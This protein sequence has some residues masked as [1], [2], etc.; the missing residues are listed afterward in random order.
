MQKSGL[1]LVNEYRHQL[2]EMLA[3]EIK[4]P[5]TVVPLASVADEYFRINDSY[6]YPA[7]RL[8]IIDQ[9]FVT[10]GEQLAYLITGMDKSP[11]VLP[12][13]TQTRI[14]QETAEETERY[15]RGLLSYT[16]KPLINI[17][18]FDNA[19]NLLRFSFK[20]GIIALA[21]LHLAEKVLSQHEQES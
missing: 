9:E 16:L 4:I 11:I 8:G 21:E 14:A 1:D 15:L 10:G 5:D 17:K 2:E 12:P 18:S 6:L 20:M 3:Q 19:R 13:L 7:T